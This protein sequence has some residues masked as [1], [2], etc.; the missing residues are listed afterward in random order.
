M[1]SRG[2]VSRGD[3]GNAEWRSRP[4]RRCL[5]A[6]DGFYEWT[7]EKGQ[8]PLPWFVRRADGRPLV[9]AGIWQDWE[10]EGQRLTTLAVVTTEAGP[11]MAAIHDR[12]PVVLEEDDWPLWLGETGAGAARLM[13]S[14]AA[15]VLSAHRVG[16]EVNSNRA[17]GPGLIVPV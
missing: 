9:L 11:G 14:T 17:T 3:G 4:V 8:T 12:E 16:T 7:R 6:A 2:W 1:R 13:R 15:G 10:R 5:I